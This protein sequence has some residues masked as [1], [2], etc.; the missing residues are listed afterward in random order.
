M[1]KNI[2]AME[3]YIIAIAIVFASIIFVIGNRYD[4]LENDSGV[5]DRLTGKTYYL[6]SEMDFVNGK[7][8]KRKAK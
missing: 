2:I 3:K 1:E 8:R 7:F 5:I 6:N 4:H